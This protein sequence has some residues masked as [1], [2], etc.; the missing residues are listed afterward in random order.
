MFNTLRTAVLLAAMTALFMVFGY[1]IGGTSGMLIAF[2]FAAGTNIF[3]YWNSDKMVLRMQG[4]QPV[5]RSR[6]PELY[7]MVDTLSRRAGI[8]TPKVYVINTDQPNAFATGRNPANA[9]VAVSTGLLRH[10]DTREVA[11]VIAHELAHIRARD[12]LTMTITATLAGAVSALAQFGLF[13]GGGNNRDNPLG[14]VGALLM[15]FLAPVAAMVVQMAVSRTREYEADK[16]G[17]AISG[18]PLALASALHKIATLAGRQVNVAAERNPAMAH[19]YIIN[20]LSGQRMD[21]LFS[22]HPDT[23]NRIVA[24]Q[25]LAATAPLADKG[26]AQQSRPQPAPSGR[27][28]SGWRVPS[29]GGNGTGA[30]RGPWG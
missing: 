27:T 26:A 9:A 15:V 21:N 2:L 11:G 14:G 23:A 7:D 28:G 17:A 30:D 6:V 5:E 18:D 25:R 22:T 10:L 19:M 13:F 1:F 20:P 8:P 16:D 4:A 3:A 12:T 24:L 29:A